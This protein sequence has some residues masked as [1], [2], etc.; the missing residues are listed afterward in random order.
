[1]AYRNGTVEATLRPDRNMVLVIGTGFDELFLPDFA[2]GRLCYGGP[3]VLYL[4]SDGGLGHDMHVVL[5]AW[6]AEPSPA[7]GELTDSTVVSLARPGIY[8]S[9]LTESAASPVLDLPE[10][11]DYVARVS[12]TGR[13]ALPAVRAAASGDRRPVEHVLVQLWPSTPSIDVNS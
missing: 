1:M 12:V 8:V 10:P 6:D 7:P 2:A 13:R 4:M 5:E 11:G 9:R 3:D